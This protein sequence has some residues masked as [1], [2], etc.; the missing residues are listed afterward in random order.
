MPGIPGGD[1]VR[2]VVEP[3]IAQRVEVDPSDVDPATALVDEAHDHEMVVTDFGPAEL[4]GVDAATVSESAV[5]RIRTFDCR[6]DLIG[7][8]LG[9]I[10]NSAPN[11]HD[12][13]R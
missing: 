13:D 7:L 5:V 8:G 9:R 12:N 10:P 3:L 6:L 2:R 1:N 4:L 11:G